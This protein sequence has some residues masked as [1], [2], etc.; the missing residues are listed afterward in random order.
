MS[1]YRRFSTDPAQAR[2]QPAR[3]KNC[4]SFKIKDRISLSELA[5]LVKNNLRLFKLDSKTLL[6]CHSAVTST[7]WQNMKATPTLTL[8]EDIS[9]KKI[10]EEAFYKAIYDLRHKATQFDFSTN[11]TPA[12]QKR[13]PGFDLTTHDSHFTILVE[14]FHKSYLSR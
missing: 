9:R 2:K 11:C 1:T 14:V 10:L 12:Q 4:F 6:V 7:K 13:F 3:A 5:G 8:L